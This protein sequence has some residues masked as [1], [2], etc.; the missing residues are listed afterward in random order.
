LIA[1][2]PLIKEKTKGVEMCGLFAP[3]QR[4]EIL[5]SEQLNSIET[6]KPVH[7]NTK[8]HIMYS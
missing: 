2:L 4:L 5:Q 1:F 8:T 6:A 3:N 7:V